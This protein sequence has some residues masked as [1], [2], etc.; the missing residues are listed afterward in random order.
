M[1]FSINISTHS[2]NIIK[3]VDPNIA[4]ERERER[5]IE[6]HFAWLFFLFFSKISGFDSQVVLIKT[7]LESTYTR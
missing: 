7:K 5:E 3:K 4:G 2:I 1:T 6:R